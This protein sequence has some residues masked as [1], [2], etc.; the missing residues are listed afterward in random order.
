MFRH[1]NVIAAAILSGAI[2]LSAVLVCIF[3]HSLD[4]TLKN[5]PMV[6]FGSNVTFPDHLTISSGNSFFEVR[7]RTSDQYPLLVKQAP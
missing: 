3:I 1:P 2:V 7:V 6:G 5:K 4:A